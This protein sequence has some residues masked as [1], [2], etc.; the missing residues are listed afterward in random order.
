MNHSDI[1]QDEIHRLHV[2][3]VLTEVFDWRDSRFSKVHT[4]IAAA[5]KAERR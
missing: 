3:R 1:S 4:A 5:R 2:N